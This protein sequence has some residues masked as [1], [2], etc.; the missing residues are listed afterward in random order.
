MF[1]LKNEKLTI[2]LRGLLCT[3]FICAFHF[4]LAS[5]YHYLTESGVTA[6]FDLAEWSY[7]FRR[8]VFGVNFFL[9]FVGVIA[10]MLATVFDPERA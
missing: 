8:I 3:V 2:L 9:L 10:T 5:L 4:V 7:P 6:I 1:G